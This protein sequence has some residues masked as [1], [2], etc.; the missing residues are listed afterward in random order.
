MADYTTQ[1]IRNIVLAGHGGAGKTTLVEA[2]LYKAG[3]INQPGSV[4]RGTTVCDF[5]PQEREH[6]HSLDT[7]IVSM[8][9]HGGHINL[10]D[11]PGY[12]DFIG[13][14]LAV[15]PA[16][17]T[18]AIVINAQTGIEMVTKS[19][20]RIT[21]ERDMERLI[22][23]N[24]IDADEVDLKGLL[25]AIREEFGTECLPLNLPANQGREVVDCFFQAAGGATDFSSVRETHTAIIDQVVELDEEL[26]ALYLEQESAVTPE[27]LHG[28]FEKALR[29]GHLVP[30]C[31]VSAQSGAGIDLLL[32]IFARLMPNPQEGNPPHFLKGDGAGAESIRLSPD[33]GRHALAHVFKV[34][35]DPFVGRMGVFRIH[36]GAIRKDGQLY[37]GDG[38][39]PVKVN[40]LLK[41]QGKE[42]SEIGKGIP[43][44]ICALAKLDELEFDTVLHDSH[45]EDNIRLEP[46]ALPA[47]MY[48]I[49]I[50]AR[51]RGD[52]QKISDALH[53][54]QAEDPSFRVEHNSNLNETV[55]KG[56]GELHLR[57]TLEKLRQRYHVEVD[58]HPPRIAYTETITASAE[59]H[60]RH[61]KQTGGAGQ[62]GEVYLRVEPL[63]RGAGFEFVDGVV[64][65]VIPRQ[66]IP[67][68]EKGILQALEQGVIAGYPLKDLRVEVYDGKYHAVDSKEIAF[69]TAGRKAFIDAVKKAKPVVL[70]PIVEISITSPNQSM[71]DITADLSGRRGRISNTTSLPGGMTTT[72]GLAPLSELGSYQS[73]LKSITGGAGSYTISLS[74]YDPVPARTQQELMAA[75]KPAAEE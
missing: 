35:I 73:T 15:L 29:D 74:H 16:A 31:F 34:T 28:A 13:R 47:P 60:H 54:L 64:G 39:K 30:I 22:I 69:V 23:I 27:Q 12:P 40:H 14:T 65:G 59:G 72:S 44:D 36:Q 38:R 25:S 33:P 57:M 1:D 75:F 8:D 24:K 10:I 68:V 58:T 32:D 41:L 45:D 9:Y 19:M 6:K 53:K 18:C 20:M 62:F 70:E 56:I 49:A 48:G 63:P 4:D 7:A 17:E 3:V 5:D 55:I 11:T 61:K 52:E 67:A 46:V 42:H 66:F 51:S 2:L 21:R 43:G 71:G 50:V 26:M 37:V